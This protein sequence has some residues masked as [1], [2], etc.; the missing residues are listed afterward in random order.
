MALYKP[1]SQQK[2][3]KTSNTSHQ[4][5]SVPYASEPNFKKTNPKLTPKKVYNF[6]KKPLN[7]STKLLTKIQEVLKSLLTKKSIALNPNKK[8]VI[9]NLYPFVASIGFIVGLP[10]TLYNLF[11]N[12]TSLIQLIGLISI[13]ISF[14]FLGL[15][16]NGLFQRYK[17]AWILNKLASIACIPGLLLFNEFGDRFVF[18]AFIIVMF[19]G[20]YQLENEYIN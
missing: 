13:T 12:T 15:S 2:W 16:L 10:L 1:T 19:Y 4:W 20:L 14:C 5:R 9:T 7:L 11:T 8:R 18:T 6:P 3:K 17:G